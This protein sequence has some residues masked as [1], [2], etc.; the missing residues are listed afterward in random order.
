VLYLSARLPTS[1][2]TTFSDLVPT[3]D[4][5]SSTWMGLPAEYSAASRLHMRLSNLSDA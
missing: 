4:L 1:F 2:L 5:R 3:T